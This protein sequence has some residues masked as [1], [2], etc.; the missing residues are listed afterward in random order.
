[1]FQMFKQF[2]LAFTAFFV[3][4]EKTANATVHLS[5]WAE[6]SAGAFADEA[7][8]QRQAKMNLMLKQERVTE[9]QLAAVTK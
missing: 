6:E 2:F 7:R 3:A 5:T 9:K 4:L 8:I 1:M